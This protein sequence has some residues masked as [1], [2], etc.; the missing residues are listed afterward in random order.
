MRVA[1]VHD[2]LT[3]MRGG[4]RV[5]EQ[6]IELFPDAEIFTLVHVQGSVARAIESRPIHTSWLNRMPGIAAHYRYY[7]PLMPRAI[8]QFDLRGFDLVI[9]SS[10]CAAKGVRVPAGV[11]HLCYCHTPMRYLYDQ[12]EAYSARW[13][14]P[15]RTAL[16]WFQPRLAR[17]DVANTERVT[18]LVAN[19]NYVRERIRRIYK[20][21]AAVVYP[22]VDVDRFQPAAQREDFYVT[23]S[24]LVPYKRVDLL[25]D[26]FNE[27]GRRLVVI[28]GGPEQK[29]LR[30]RARSNV[31][32]TG[33][34]GD[35]E[36][37]RLLGRAR[38][39]VFAAV[40]DFGIAPVE[41]QAAGA[42]VI[43][44]RAGGALE[45]VRE[46][47]TG[48]F[49]NEQTPAALNAAV[50]AAEGIDFDVSKLTANAQQFRPEKFRRALRAQVDALLQPGAA[51]AV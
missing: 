37:A 3:G 47:E 32:F 6:M 33:Q 30:A 42:P 19:S 20:R 49:F 24:A 29:R 35:G 25:V 2:W 16:S 46:G 4:E 15:T 12:A 48:V 21:A 39:F 23:V 34:I 31:R 7:L 44:Y 50:A 13:S 17:W 45:T 40:E 26:A 1:L 5:L 38:G 10:H 14:L 8:E 41:A 22:P 27:S 43:A 9:S 51:V 28:G 18:Q 36:V 11:P